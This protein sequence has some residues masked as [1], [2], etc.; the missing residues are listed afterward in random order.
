MSE[1]DEACLSLEGLEALRLADHEGLSQERAALRMDV[2]R[3]TFGR[4]LARA[5]QTVAQTLVQGLALKI[6]GGHYEV[7]TSSEADPAPCTV[8]PADFLS[9]PTIQEDSMEITKLAISSEGP[10]PQDIVDPRFGRAVGFIIYDTQTDDYT[11]RENGMA[12][13]M[14]QGAGIQTAENI[15]KAGVQAVLTG[16]VGPKAFAVLE[17]AGVQVGLNFENLKVEQVY[18]RFKQGKVQWSKQPNK[19]DY[20]R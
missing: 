6:E 20:G 4:I 2:S 19:E 8:K 13:T 14:A 16:S 3:Q 12:M 9:P 1:L 15:V 7:G 10:T 5:R 17:A 18:D 11:Y